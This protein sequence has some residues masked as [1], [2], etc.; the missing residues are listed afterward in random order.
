MKAKLYISFVLAVCFF[1]SCGNRPSS[2]LSE[3]KMESVLYDLYIAEIEIRH[4][5]SEFNRD[6]LLKGQ[7]LESVFKK[8][9]ISKAKFDTSLVW[10]VANLEKYN[11]INDRLIARYDVEIAL[12]QKQQ[13]EIEK[14][15]NETVTDTTF[16]YS[17]ET[18]IIHPA[19]RNNLFSFIID[20]KVQLN[21][22]KRYY[23]EFQTIGINNITKPPIF[24]FN[25]QCNDTTYVYRDTIKEDIFYKKDHF[26]PLMKRAQKIY[27]S[28]YIPEEINKPIF[29]TNFNIT[30]RKTRL[31][32]EN[33]NTNE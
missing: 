32:N 2:V 25:I 3:K 31:L 12:L 18:I 15:K 20:E 29:I 6:T 19:Y 14:K 24:T 28:I 4:N 13:E 22:Q 9:R 1:S 8:N 27:G 7:L 17:P 11:K 10:Y 21:K 23:I 5:A 16:I 30:Q 33:S 26:L